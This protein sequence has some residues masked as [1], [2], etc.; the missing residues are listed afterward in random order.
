MLTTSCQEITHLQKSQSCIT[1][2]WLKDTLLSI[3]QQHYIGAAANLI[4]VLKI[5]QQQ[6]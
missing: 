4:I 2:I 6:V 3:P 5:L 1:L